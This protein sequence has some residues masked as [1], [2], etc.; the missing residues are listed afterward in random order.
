MADTF[1]P[2]LQ[3][4]GIRD[5]EH[6]PN[7]YRLL[8]VAMY[9]SDPEV[10]VNAADRQ[11]LYVRTFQAGKYSAPSQR[12]LNE[13]SLAKVCLLNAE[14]KAAYDAQL[15]AEPDGQC[16]CAAARR[17][18]RRTLFVAASVV[19]VVWLISLVWLLP[20]PRRSH[21]EPRPLQAS[22]AEVQKALAEKPDDPQAR[23]IV[24]RY[25]CL[26]ED[27]WLR[28]LPLL[29]GD[30]EAIEAAIEAELTRTPASPADMVALGDRWHDAVQGVKESNRHLARVRARY[31]YE[32]ALPE[33][34]GSVRGT[35]ER[36]LTELSP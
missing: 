34:I 11:M 9:E 6:P 8:G 15:Q 2:Y 7:H 28:G 23:P 18:A 14:K 31:W 22:F 36:R 30:D 27:D 25:C 3:W 24:G 19:A 12:L 16:D 4:L 29:K 35:V 33:L 21:E 5:P 32:R 17:A 13:L 1:D 20:I 10:L 26:I